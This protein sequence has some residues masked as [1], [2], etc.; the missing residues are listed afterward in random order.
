MQILSY[1]PRDDE[2]FVG[3]S[4]EEFEQ[5]EKKYKI[6]YGYNSNFEKEKEKA[7]NNYISEDYNK[8]LKDVYR[9]EKIPFICIVT[10]RNCCRIIIVVKHFPFANLWNAYSP[11]E[12]IRVQEIETLSFNDIKIHYIYFSGVLEVFCDKWIEKFSAKNTNPYRLLKNDEF[13]NYCKS[14]GWV[15]DNGKSFQ[16]YYPFEFYEEALKYLPQVTD[17]NRL[18]NL[19]F[20]YWQSFKQSTSSEKEILEHKNWFVKTLGRLKELANHKNKRNRKGKVT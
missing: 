12:Q 5:V 11:W 10:D 20:S 4:L 15:E 2:F 18:G 1:N 7:L 3:L 6:Y 14:F 17:R 13:P 16:E 8:M 9:I 19:I